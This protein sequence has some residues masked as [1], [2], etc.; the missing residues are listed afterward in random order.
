MNHV[1]QARLQLTREPKQWPRMRI[2]PEV[3]DL[4]AFRLEDFRLDD[5]EPWPHIPAPIAV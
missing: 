3:N 5:Y 2:N 4:F 1:D